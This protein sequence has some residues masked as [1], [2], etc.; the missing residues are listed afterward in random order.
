MTTINKIAD[1]IRNDS[2]TI[3]DIDYYR[4]IGSLL[5]NLSGTK[6]EHIGPIFEALLAEY[7][8][9]KGTVRSSLAKIALADAAPHM[10]ATNQTVIQS[11]FTGENHT[12]YSEPGWNDEWNLDYYAEAILI[13]SIEKLNQVY[14]DLP[15]DDLGIVDADDGDPYGQLF[16]D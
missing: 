2:K 7:N 6:P 15:P 16:S 14:E 8:G 1:Y 12:S 13:E 4:A 3:D 10:N 9:H 11:M 5:V